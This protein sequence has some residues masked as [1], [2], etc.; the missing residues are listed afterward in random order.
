[1]KL[2]FNYI[3]VEKDVIPPHCRKPRDVGGNAGSV[4]V[5]IAEIDSPPPVAFELHAADLPV[6]RWYWF[7]SFLWLPALT[8]PVFYSWD[9]ARAGIT[10]AFAAWRE[11]GDRPPFE[12]WRTNEENQAAAQKWASERLITAGVVYWKATEPMI[13][14]VPMHGDAYLR[15]GEYHASKLLNAYSVDQID[16]A[17]AKAHEI[18][19]SVEVSFHYDL[20]I[21][22]ALTY[23]HSEAARAYRAA[24]IAAHLAQIEDYRHEIA[25]LE[26]YIE[27]EQTK[28]REIEE[29]IPS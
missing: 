20:F 21:P 18:A 4:E 5:E 25:R 11:S 10:L 24:R 23:R 16:Q 1:M 29:A 22:E 15:T 9:T 27:W 28:I 26:S 3:Y 8:Q 17:L 14:I 6:T 7:N 13:E 12:R 2:Q 19:D